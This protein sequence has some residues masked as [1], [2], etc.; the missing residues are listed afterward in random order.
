MS[1]FVSTSVRS[2][3][4]RRARYSGI[5]KQ[6]LGLYRSMLR[7]V[8]T[9]PADGQ[10]VW[11]EHIRA[12]FNKSS[13]LGRGNVTAI[14]HRLR[15]GTRQLQLVEQPNVPYLAIKTIPR[16]KQPSDAPSS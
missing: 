4:S 3:M 1:K 10:T 13:G 15:I 8:N 16:R 11:R 6:V 9:K 5:Q 14:E 12:E 2:S 7:A